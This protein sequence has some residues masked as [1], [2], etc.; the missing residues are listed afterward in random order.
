M[1]EDI[2]KSR[3]AGLLAADN[4]TPQKARILLALALSQTSDKAEIARMFATY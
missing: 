4:L 3:E 2:Q 1:K